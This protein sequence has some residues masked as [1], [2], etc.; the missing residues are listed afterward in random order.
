MPA[1]DDGASIRRLDPPTLTGRV[2]R[3]EP[4]SVGHAVDLGAA[5]AE[6]RASF[7]WTV[8]PNGLDEAEDY[9]AVQLRRA[10]AGETVPFA[11]IDTRD[12]R[13]VGCT[14]YL[15]LRYAFDQPTPFAVEIGGTWL[16]RSAQRTGLNLEAKLLLLAHAFEAWHVTRVDLK[17]DARNDQ[18][19][20]AIAGLGA[21]FEGVLR[22]WQPSLRA[23]EEEQF[24]DSA[25]Y[26]I[27]GSEWPGV[28]ANLRQR[29]GWPRPT[30]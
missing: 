21:H 14:S 18:S 26:S 25:L 10:A 6:D 4:L 28:E 17:S 22:A 9:V 5:G 3:L 27:L 1:P 19:R 20:R 24:R 11:Q 12:G 13:A 29:A 23:G 16:A 30:T 15:N 2:L 8:V 7:E